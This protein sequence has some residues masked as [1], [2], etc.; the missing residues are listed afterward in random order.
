MFFYV[1]AFSLFIGKVLRNDD[2]NK[3]F[4]IFDEIKSKNKDDRKLFI[5]G[6]VIG[7]PGNEAF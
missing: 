3:K 1:L 4:Y 6:Q 5:S 2:K 7:L